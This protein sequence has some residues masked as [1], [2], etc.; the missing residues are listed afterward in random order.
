MR[1]GD[2]MDSRLAGVTLPAKALRCHRA[3]NPGP[4]IDACTIGL[5]DS[6]VLTPLAHSISL[7]DQCKCVS[8]P[9]L[10]KEEV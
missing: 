10:T 9:T 3:M 4:S 1:M 5:V 7:H 2:R 6:L 8:G